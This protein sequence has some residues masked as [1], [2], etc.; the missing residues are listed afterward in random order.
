MTSRAYKSRIR[1]SK[2]RL[3]EDLKSLARDNVGIDAADFVA[4][5]RERLNCPV[6][7]EYAEALVQDAAASVGSRP[8]G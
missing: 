4:L 6:A 5:A 7:S 3:D 2:A 8:R 1:A